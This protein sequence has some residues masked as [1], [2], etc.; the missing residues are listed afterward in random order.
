V[1]CRFQGLESPGLLEL[2]GLDRSHVYTTE[3]MQDDAHKQVPTHDSWT[4]QLLPAV[5]PAVSQTDSHQTPG[6]CNHHIACT[7]FMTCRV[8]CG[9]CIPSSLCRNTK[10]EFDIN[11]LKG[12]VAFADR[13]TTVSPRY[14]HEV[15]N[16]EFGMGLQGQLQR[17]AQVRPRWGSD[18]NSGWQAGL[19]L[20]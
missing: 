18:R 16:T 11:L 4:Q 12:G 17:A 3:R 20:L 10:G 2:A 9:A 19:G 14:A 1:N 6:Y 5:P 15:L 7:H 13:T 8:S